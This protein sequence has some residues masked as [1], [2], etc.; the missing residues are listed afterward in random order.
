MVVVGFL[1]SWTK[2]S[3]KR[4][5]IET[6]TAQWTNQSMSKCWN[7]CFSD[8]EPTFLSFS[9]CPEKREHE[10]ALRVTEWRQ[11]T[12]RSTSCAGSLLDGFSVWNWLSCWGSSCFQH[13]PPFKEPWNGY[14][15]LSRTREKFRRCGPNSWV[16]N[17]SGLTGVWVLHGLKW[18]Q[19][20]DG[21]WWFS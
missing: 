20:F 11:W 5:L 3:W 17:I 2:C 18:W 1:S 16:R 15:E 19:W 4:C 13:F 8:N 10:W 9:D 7:S 6:V 14:Q 21:Q 12:S